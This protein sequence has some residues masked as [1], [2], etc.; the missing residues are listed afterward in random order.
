MQRAYSDTSEYMLTH[1][2]VRET[3]KRWRPTERWELRLSRIRGS[4]RRSKPSIRCANDARGVYAR[5]QGMFLEIDVAG[6]A[7]SPLDVNRIF[8]LLTEPRRISRVVTADPTG[9]DMWC[10]VTGWSDDGP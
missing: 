7:N 2:G 1:L 4:A 3:C 6:G 8:D 9:K 10:Q 5:I